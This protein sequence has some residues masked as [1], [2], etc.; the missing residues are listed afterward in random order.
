MNSGAAAGPFLSRIKPITT[1]PAAPI[2]S[3]SGARIKGAKQIP[4]A[5]LRK[6]WG[7]TSKK[8]Q[9][10]STGLHPGG[11]FGIPRFQ[12]SADGPSANIPHQREFSKARRPRIEGRVEGWVGG[13]EATPGFEPGDEGFAGPCLTT[14]PRRLPGGQFSPRPIKGQEP[15]CPSWSSFSILSGRRSPFFGSLETFGFLPGLQHRG[16]RRP[17]RIEGWAGG[18][19]G[20]GDGI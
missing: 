9:A 7:L 15:P 19:G 16:T 6:P 11:V 4:A 17:L 20:A 2:R 10:P 3:P 14:W 13:L 1:S 18:W 5:M 12:F 8:R